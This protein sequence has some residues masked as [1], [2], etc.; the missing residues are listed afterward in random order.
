MCLCLL[1]GTQGPGK[2]ADLLDGDGWV[3]FM[4]KLRP[5]ISEEGA[6]VLFKVM[7]E[8]ETGVVRG[9]GGES[10]WGDLRDAP[11]MHSRSLTTAAAAAAAADHGG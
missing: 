10:L 2:F 3:K 1:L 9:R 7:D 5:D 11:C 4:H 8:Q 6:R